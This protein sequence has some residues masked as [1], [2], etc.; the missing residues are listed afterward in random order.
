MFDFIKPIADW[1]T[2][3]RELNGEFKNGS[4]LTPARLKIPYG[5]NTYHIETGFSGDNFWRA[6][7]IIHCEFLYFKQFELEIYKNLLTNNNQ[8]YPFRIGL[9]SGFEELG[10]RIQDLPILKELAKYFD[11]YRLIFKTE[12]VIKE[13]YDVLPIL[14]F[15][16]DGYIRSKDKFEIIFK[17]M[18]DISNELLKDEIIKS[19]I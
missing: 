9:T 1:Q 11:N 10:E 5:Q 7:T 12:G 14:Q 18:Q 15:K 13:N 2:I 8:E 4:I 17:C 6:K 19:S 16:T 3:A